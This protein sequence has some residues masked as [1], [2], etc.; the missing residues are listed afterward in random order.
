MKKLLFLTLFIVTACSLP[1]AVTPTPTPTETPL[2]SPVATVQVQPTAEPGTESNPLILAL[3]PSPHTDQNAI[4]AANALA[5]KLEDV[6]GYQIVTV[7]PAYEADLVQDFA[8]SNAHIGLLSPYGYFLASENGDVN[9]LLASL[10]NGQTLYGAQFLARNDSGFKRYYDAVRDED[11]AEAEEALAQFS[12]G[13][14]CWS[15]AVS[16][17]GYVIPLGFLM[18]AGVQTREAAFVEGQGTVVRAIYGKDICDFGATY[19]DARDLP[20]LEQDYPDV[21]EKVVVVWRIPPI[22]P[23]EQIVVSS[24]LN[25]QVKQSLLRAF[26]DLMGTEEGKALIQTVYG[27]DAFQPADENQ[28]QQFGEFL[29]ASNLDINSLLR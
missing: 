11:T 6:T 14:P 27:I 22:I 19:I 1:F 2:A 3:V 10:R 15:D 29:K 23:Y 18:Q 9:A 24:R 16:P 20:A 8:V 25:P 5:Q 17:S 4:D 12:E 13:K 26:I 28:Y 21:M 7:S